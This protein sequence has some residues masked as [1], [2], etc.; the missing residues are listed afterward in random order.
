[1]KLLLGLYGSETMREQK[2]RN[3]SKVAK[4]NIQ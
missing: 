1:M 4:N 3:K 2:E